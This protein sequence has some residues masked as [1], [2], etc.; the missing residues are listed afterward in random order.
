MATKRDLAERFWSKVDIKG[1]NECWLWKASTLDGKY[2]QFWY[3]GK[4][5]GAHIIAMK[6]TGH[7]KP[8]GLIA[9]HSCSKR[10]RCCNP[11][12]ITWGTEE[13]NIRE[14]FDRGERKKH[15]PS[16]L[17]PELVFELRTIYGAGGT[18]HRKLARQ[19]D[20]PRQTLVDALNGKTFKNVQLSQLK[21]LK[22]LEKAA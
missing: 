10:Y 21:Q 11:A 4:M 7:P 13:E 8:P 16:R 12:H 14:A 15:Y 22:Q 20:I 5:I 3:R 17:T 1:P 18:S 9:R 6:L 2:G 19:Y